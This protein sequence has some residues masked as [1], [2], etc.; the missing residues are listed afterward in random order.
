MKIGVFTVSTPEFDVAETVALLKRIGCDGVEWRVSAPAPAEKPADYTFE[1]RYWSFNQS[2]IDVERAQTDLPRAADAARAAGIEPFAA[3][4]YLRVTQA[5]EEAIG[6]VMRAAAASGMTFMR[7]PIPGFDG[8]SRYDELF[9]R[10]REAIERLVP[11]AETTGIRLCFEMHMDTIMPSASSARRLLDG[12]PPARVG[13]I[14]DPGNLV[15]E[16]YEDY[17]MGVQI[18]GNYLAYVHV[19]NARWVRANAPVRNGWKWEWAPMADGS[20]DFALV[21]DA[22]RQVGY[23]GWLSIE[24]FSNDEPTEPKLA[25]VVSQLRQLCADRGTR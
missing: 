13:V 17:R 1:K 8:S 21:I 11:L 12:L 2:T 23:D 5:T 9:T 25:G 19:K 20:A 24:D 14:Y 6:S 16:G 18:L 3:T 4:T 15:I 22:L 10:T 7:C